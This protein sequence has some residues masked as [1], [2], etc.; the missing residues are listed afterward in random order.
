MGQHMSE[1]WS[2]FEKYLIGR[3]DKIEDKLT[4]VRIKMA[5][6]A[7]IISLATS[8][9]TATVVSKAKEVAIPPQTTERKE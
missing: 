2:D 3:I 4:N 6:M 7:V 5:S 8:A 1:N 9:I